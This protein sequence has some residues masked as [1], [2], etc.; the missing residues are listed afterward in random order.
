MSRV[1]VITGAARGLGAGLARSLSQRP[2]H[3]RPSVHPALRAL[4]SAPCPPR[5]TAPSV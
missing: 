2:P 1:V 4:P 3:T 5:C